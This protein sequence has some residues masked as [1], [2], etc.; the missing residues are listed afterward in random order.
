MKYNRRY[1]LPMVIGL[2]C[3]LFGGCGT[4]AQSAS[5]QIMNEYG[6]S[7]NEKQVTIDG[8]GSYDFLFIS[9]V[10]LEQ[11]SVDYIEA[12]NMTSDDRI[13]MFS[14]VKGIPSSEQFAGYVKLAD[15]LKADAFLMGGDIIDFL[16]EANTTYVQDVLADIKTPWLYT[17]GN[18]DAYD[19]L[20]LYGGSLLK[21]H[22]LLAPFWKYGD[23]QCQV[24]AFDDFNLVSINDVDKKRRAVVTPEA[25]A[26][27]QKIYDE[28][29]PIILL[30]HVPMVSDQTTA[31]LEQTRSM[32]SSDGVMGYGLDYELSEETKVFYDMV[33][34][35]DS[36]VKLVLAGHVHFPSDDQLN[37]QLRQIVNSTSSDGSAT[38]I[39]IN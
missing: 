27:F 20:K 12:W 30:M 14:N 8:I 3:L 38:Y 18:H 36:L 15:A 23:A 31:F 22:E 13:T 28:G 24:M 19:V 21:D 26:A 29:K 35:P 9:D 32:A 16:S 7:L 39:H 34:Q 25:L 4:A 37:D 5:E 1:C 11:K 17:M 33:M 6:L 10:H 2:I